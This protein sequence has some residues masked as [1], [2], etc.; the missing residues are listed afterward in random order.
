MYN[1]HEINGYTVKKELGSGGVTK[2]YHAKHELLEREFALKVLIADD[3][4]LREMFL[5]ETKVVMKFHHPNVITEYDI[6]MTDLHQGK[7]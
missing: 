7:S 5:N 4:A 3:F 1:L 2:M 6:G